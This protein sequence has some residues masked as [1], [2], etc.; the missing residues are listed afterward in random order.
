[1]PTIVH[2]DVPA[3]D[4]SRAREFYSGLFLWNFIAPPGF[5]D[6]YLIETQGL[7]GTPSIGGGLGKRRSPDQRILNYLGIPAI[8][9]YAARVK[10]LGGFVVVPKMS[11]PGFGYLAICSDTEGNLSGLWQD[12]PGAV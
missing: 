4:P 5:P 6:Y 11:V 2:F 12:D 1:M 9:D 10:Q 3:D 7:D 8:D